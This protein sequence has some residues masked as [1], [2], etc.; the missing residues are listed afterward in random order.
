M[1]KKVKRAAGTSRKGGASA[2][3]KAVIDDLVMGNRILYLVWILLHIFRCTRQSVC[4][5]S[6]RNNFS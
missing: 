6:G 3:Y 5:V 4:M 1:V 2:E